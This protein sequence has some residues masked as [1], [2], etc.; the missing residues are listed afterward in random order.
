MTLSASF[1]GS[2][3]DLASS[4]KLN[5]DWNTLTDKLIVICFKMGKKVFVGRFF[6]MSSHLYEKVCPPVGQSKISFIFDKF[7]YQID[8]ERRGLLNEA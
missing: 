7:D 8:F 2:S 1:G 3:V 6:D 4:G 5:T